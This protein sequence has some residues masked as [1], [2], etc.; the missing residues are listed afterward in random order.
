MVQMPHALGDG[1]IGGGIKLGSQGRFRT[2]PAL[3]SWRR[4][5][6]WPGKVRQTE[7]MRSAREVVLDR[8]GDHEELAGPGDGDGHQGASKNCS[9]ALTADTG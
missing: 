1:N 2:I 9:P 3:P 6:R 8:P 7:A 4:C 5:P